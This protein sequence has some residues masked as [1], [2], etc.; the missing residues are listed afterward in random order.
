DSEVNFELQAKASALRPAA[1]IFIHDIEC[2]SGDG[3]QIDLRKA[4]KLF[5]EAFAAIWTAKAESDGFNRLILTLPCSWREAALIRALARYRQQPGLDPSQ[6]I[7]EQALAANPRIAQLMLT[8]FK[9]RFDPNLQVA[10]D[11]RQARSSKLE[12]MI[13]SALSEVVSLDDDRAL[14]RI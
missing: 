10:Q 1:R 8:L 7:Q 11:T 3:K 13:E 6:P 2:R 12:F 5:E 14:R 9:A 4:G